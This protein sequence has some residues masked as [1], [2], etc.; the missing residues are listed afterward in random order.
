ME[1]QVL[2]NTRTG[3]PVATDLEVARSQRERT[4]GLLGRT[5]LAE[6]GGMRF[7]GTNSIHMF[8]MRFPI[9]VVYLDRRG[10]VIKLVHDLAPWRM[11][12]A[13]R[14]RTTIELPAGTIR[15][16]ALEVG[17]FLETRA[18]EGAA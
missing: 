11:S 13:W 17:D 6:G 12:A 10:R 8:F 9:D 7:D 3:E 14:A 5:G 16:C 15:R 4:R 2:V 1:R 18:V